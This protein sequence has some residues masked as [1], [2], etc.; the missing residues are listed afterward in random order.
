MNLNS[1]KICLN[2]EFNHTFLNSDKLSLQ[3]NPDKADCKLISEF[4]E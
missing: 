1:A 3:L 2:S 4:K